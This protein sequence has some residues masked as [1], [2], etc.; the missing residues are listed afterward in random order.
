[1]CWPRRCPCCVLAASV[2][3]VPAPC[4][5][6]CLPH[7]RVLLGCVACVTCMLLTGL[8]GCLGLASS[9]LCACN[10]GALQ[11]VEVSALS[12]AE[13]RTRLEALRAKYDEDARALQLRFEAAQA[14]LSRELAA[15]PK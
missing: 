15:R 2:F 14:A 7:R 1:M 3:C 5:S 4:V 10:L 9:R 8:C 11:V 12:T 13:L 6:L